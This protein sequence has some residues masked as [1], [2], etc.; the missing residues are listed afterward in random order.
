MAAIVYHAPFPLDREASS[1]SGVRPVR[2]LDAFRELGYT[3]LD[4]TGS[5]RERSRRLRALRDRLQGG[6]RIEF[7]YSECATM[8]TMLADPRHLPPHP[9]VDPALMRLM[10]QHGVPT[11]LFYRDIYWAF[12]DYRE[13][14]G[15]ALATAMG[16]VYRYDLAWYSRYIDRLYLPSMR[17]GAHVPGFPEE[18]MAPLP[19]GCEIVDEAPSSRPDQWETAGDQY[20]D[21]VEAS[22]GRIEVVH[23][24]GEELTALYERADLCVLF[25]EPDPYREFASPVKL[26]E[27]LGRGKPVIAS[28]GTLAAEVVG[29]AGAGWTL[30]YDAGELSG[31]LRGLLERP[32]EVAEAAGRAREARQEHTWLSRA[33]TVAQDM[34]AVRAGALA[35]TLRAG[36]NR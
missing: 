35:R 1:A 7:L 17:M 24:S 30:P 16:C 31:L 18:R 23:R 34:Q 3:V 12:P 32:Q 29:A 15:A 36:G 20:A 26:Y 21:L 13:R 28:Q 4:V 19:P 5:A 25:V 10:H 9:F 6:E 8:P 27:Y 14:V 11:S 22:G 2:M 33:R